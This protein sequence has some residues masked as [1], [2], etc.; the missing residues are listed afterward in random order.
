MARER[1]R[2]ASGSLMNS[3]FAG[4]Y[5]MSRL[6]HMQ[7]LAQWTAVME[8]YITS[9]SATVRRRYLTQ[10]S[11]LRMWLIGRCVRAM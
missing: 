7:M 8:R 2:L 5:R 6:S 11:Q 10:S 1:R 4:S 3:A 9:G